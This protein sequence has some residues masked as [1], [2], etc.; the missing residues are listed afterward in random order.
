MTGLT[1]AVLLLVVKALFFFA[2]NG[3]PR[4]G[5]RAAASPCCDR[6]PTASTSATS[7]DGRGPELEAAGVTDAAS[8]TPFYWGEQFG[9]RRH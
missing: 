5:A 6:A 7:Q 2:D 3:Y 8:F 4:P 1:A 9:T